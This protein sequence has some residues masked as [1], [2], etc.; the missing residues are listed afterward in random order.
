MTRGRRATTLAALGL[1]FFAVLS[2]ARAAT[3]TVSFSG[4]VDS[5]WYGSVC[6]YFSAP[7]GSQFSG[8]IT[9]DTA[10]ATDS[11]PNS[12]IGVY[13][14]RIVDAGIRIGSF[15]A[16][17]SLG[18]NTID[19]FNSNPG[20][21][22]SDTLTLSRQMSPAPRPDLPPGGTLM[23]LELRDPYAT[24]VASD[25][26]PLEF[27]VHGSPVG[28]MHMPDY[29]IRW[30]VTSAS[31][32]AVPIPAAAPLLLSGL[33]LLIPARRRRRSLLSVVSQR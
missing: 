28:Y 2:P 5:C 11:D 6:Y 26:L 33:A 32:T 29:G 9:Y 10:G 7:P 24:A 17:D 22:S 3:V 12:A 1:A 25:A 30:Q 27:A 16:A 14:G 15:G 4:T 31:F 21:P 8:F 18:Q 20:S 23:Y 19:V 13:Q